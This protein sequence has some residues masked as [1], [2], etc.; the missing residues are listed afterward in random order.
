MQLAAYGLAFLKRIEERVP[1]GINWWFTSFFEI[2]FEGASCG[3]KVYGRLLRNWF[4]EDH[5]PRNAR[6]LAAC[7]ML[8]STLSSFLSRNLRLQAADCTLYG[9]NF[10]N[11]F[12]KSLTAGCMLH[13][14]CWLAL[15]LQFFREILDNRPQAACPMLSASAMLG[16]TLCWILSRN[17][18]PSAS[19]LNAG[20]HI[21][22]S[23]LE[24]S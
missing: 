2:F 11:S 3:P 9:C 4:T 10:F 17:L 8:A 1:A 18:S 20:W 23:S 15:S 5:R 19:Q 16:G 6:P 21:S 22:L 24:K 14:P 12:E 13:A 7:P